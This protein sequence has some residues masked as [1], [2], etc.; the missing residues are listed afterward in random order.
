[1]L[2]VHATPREPAA[3]P[4]LLLILACKAGRVVPSGLPA[5][6]EVTHARHH[7][8]PWPATTDPL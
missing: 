4:G 1:V 3:F 7:G 5:G 6:V 2:T 8:G